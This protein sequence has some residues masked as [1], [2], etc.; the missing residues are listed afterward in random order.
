MK[1]ETREFLEDILI[2]DTASNNSRR[3]ALELLISAQPEDVIKRKRTVF[4]R[5]S[6]ITLTKEDFNKI[7]AFLDD[8]LKVKLSRCFKMLQISS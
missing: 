8:T 3:R 1:T 5:D 4:A 6:S 7:M 2:R